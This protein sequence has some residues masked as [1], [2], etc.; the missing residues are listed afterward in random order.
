MLVRSVPIVVAAIALVVPGCIDIEVPIAPGL[1]ATGTSFVV[2]G[3]A[4]LIDE[5][6]PCLVWMGENGV[7]YHLFQDPRVSNEDFDAVTAPGITSRLKLAVRTD[8]YV[9]CLVGTVVE[10]QDVLEIVE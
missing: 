6:G 9:D 3:T 7:T 2:S 10:V 8:L 4:A 1:F 5:D